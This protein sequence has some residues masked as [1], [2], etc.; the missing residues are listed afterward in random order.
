[1]FKINVFVIAFLIPVPLCATEVSSIPSCKSS[2]DPIVRGK[3]KSLSHAPLTLSLKLVADNLRVTDA[4][5]IDWS[6]G[7]GVV[8]QR[9]S[10][11]WGITGQNVEVKVIEGR[12]ITKSSHGE[13]PLPVGVPPSFGAGAE[14]VNSDSVLSG[15]WR[16]GLWHEPDGHSVVALYRPGEVSA[17]RPIFYSE[18]PL[19][20]LSYLPSPDALGGSFTLWQKIGNSRYRMIALYWSEEIIH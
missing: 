15:G 3:V 1:M 6:Q 9:V 5:E 14:F 18:K 20:G 12:I 4:S 7:C 2:G 10:Y 17:P 8:I 11:G 19:I 16:A 13:A